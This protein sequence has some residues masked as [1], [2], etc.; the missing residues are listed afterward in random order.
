MN[1]FL[2]RSLHAYESTK[3]GT[4][5]KQPADAQTEP[6]FYTM[7][8]QPSWQAP[9]SPGMQG[10]QG[11]ANLLKGIAAGIP[12]SNLS[13]ATWPSTQ[14]NQPFCNRCSSNKKQRYNKQRTMATQYYIQTQ[15][16]PAPNDQQQQ[17]QQPAPAS[18]P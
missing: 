9:A 18:T 8:Q 14:M 3:V 10:L 17:Q 4:G 11:A 12:A 5:H 7:P 2:D 13:T 1:F 16:A 6:N 15:Q